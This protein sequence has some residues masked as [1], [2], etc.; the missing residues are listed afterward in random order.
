MQKYP[1][2][3]VNGVILAYGQFF[4]YEHVLAGLSSDSS[5]EYLKSKLIDNNYMIY[6]FLQDGTRLAACTCLAEIL[7]DW[8]SEK[9]LLSLHDALGFIAEVFLNSESRSVKTAC[10]ETLSYFIGLGLATD[11]EF[12]AGENYLNILMKL[13]SLTF[14][15][16]NMK[17]QK[18]A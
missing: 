12:L 15:E 4:R 6:G 11:D 7:F 17:L 16:E 9:K 2:D 14:K 10:F 3:F 18:L 5:L 8:T 1:T 13:A